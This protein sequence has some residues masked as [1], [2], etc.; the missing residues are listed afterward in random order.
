MLLSLASQLLVCVALAAQCRSEFSAR[1]PR[2]P[3]SLPRASGAAAGRGSA[4]GR[5]S[6]GSLLVRAV[7]SLALW[8]FAECMSKSELDKQNCSL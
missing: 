8:E 7:P 6:Q 2:L 1:S 5:L 4:T 3:K